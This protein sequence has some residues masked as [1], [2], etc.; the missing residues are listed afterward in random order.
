MFVASSGRGWV[1]VVNDHSGDDEPD[2]HDDP[3]NGSQL[4]ENGC[5][6]DVLSERYVESVNANVIGALQT[7]GSQVE[8]S[9]SSK[10]R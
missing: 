8:S 2:G 7:K 3:D 9:T 1:Q 6:F 4:N 10:R 5:Y